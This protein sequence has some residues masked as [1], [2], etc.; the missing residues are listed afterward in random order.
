ML[1]LHSCFLL[2]IVCQSIYFGI[3]FRLSPIAE[4]ISFKAFAA[5]GLQRFYRENQAAEVGLHPA[6]ALEKS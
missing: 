4:T 3:E 2:A 5:R 6:A 1:F